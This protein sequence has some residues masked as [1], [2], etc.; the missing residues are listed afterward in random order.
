MSTEK[1]KIEALKK[2]LFLATANRGLVYTAV[3]NE[4]RKELGGKRRARYSSVRS[5]ITA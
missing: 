3:L 1:E 2:D 5:I 4:L